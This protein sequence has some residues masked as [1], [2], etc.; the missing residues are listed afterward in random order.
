MRIVW[1]S[2][3]QRDLLSISSYYEAVASKEVANRI[4][5]C[6]ILSASRLM[7]NPYLG[8]PSDSTDGVHELQVAR[9]PYLLPY[10]V[11]DD[12]IEILR[13]FHESQDRPSAWQAE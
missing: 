10:R 6:I 13:V 1:L 12:R 9:L 5:R 3:A 2:F 11:V 8:H 4:M 7:D